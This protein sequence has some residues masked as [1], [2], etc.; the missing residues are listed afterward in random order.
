VGSVRRAVGRL[1]ERS[2]ELVILVHWDGFSIAQAARLLSM[3]ASTARTRYGR[4]LHRLRRDLDDLSVT[5]E[6]SRIHA[7]G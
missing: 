3:N 4:A 7:G 5:D 2:R 1:D 6:P